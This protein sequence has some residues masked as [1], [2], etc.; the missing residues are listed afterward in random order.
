LRNQ[1]EAQSISPVEVMEQVLTR[2]ETASELNAF[3]TI[4]HEGAVAQARA[5]ETAFRDSTVDGRPLLGIPVSVKDL[6]PTA[7]MRTTRGSLLADRHVPTVD[8]PAVRRL[9]DAGAIVFAKTSTSEAGWKAD[10]GSRLLPSAKNP[11]NTAYS[12]GGSS[13]GA[14][15]AA[16]LDLGPVAIGTDGAGSVRIP[17]SYCGVA[18]FKPSFGR[19]P[20]WPP[21]PERLSHVGVLGRHV[22]DIAAATAILA[23]PDARDPLSIDST[24]EWDISVSTTPRTLSIG[25][26][27]R[28][29]DETA[30]DAVIDACTN[31]AQVL[32]AFG[33]SVT[34]FDLELDAPYEVLDTLWAGHEAA[35]HASNLD[36]IADKLDAGYEVLVRRGRRMSAMQLAEAHSRRAAITQSVFSQME[37]VDVILTPTMPTDPFPLGKSG[38]DRLNGRPV[39]GLE[40]TPFTY[41]FNLTGQPAI[42]VPAALSPRGLPIGIQFVGKWRDDVTVLRIALEFESLR[43]WDPDYSTLNK[44]TATMARN[45]S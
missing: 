3:L 6:L 33:H 37:Q 29:G 31:A 21:S 4:D 12:A 13:G 14:A 35:S 16:A 42:T 41:P 15:V 8:A 2:A 36:E 43:T 34:E 1:Y 26:V 5:A 9:K 20:Y 24:L 27:T 23:G 19:V 25:L 17:A 40:W 22:S 38:H 11:W 7:G 30:D 39:A 28:L 18:G 10:S 32:G 45:G 44:G